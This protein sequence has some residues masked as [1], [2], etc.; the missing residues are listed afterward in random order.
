M[1]LVYLLT[2]ASVL[3]LDKKGLSAFLFDFKAIWKITSQGSLSYLIVLFWYLMITTIVIA[4]IIIYKEKIRAYFISLLL[5]AALISTTLLTLAPTMYAS[6]WRTIFVPS[7]IL[8]VG[9]LLVFSDIY[10][11]SESTAILLLVALTAI[12]LSRYI[13]VFHH[14]SL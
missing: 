8:A 1:P 6:G 13:F 11:N 4:P 9:L 10:D 14:L 5:S 3:L 7:C 2:A 12:G